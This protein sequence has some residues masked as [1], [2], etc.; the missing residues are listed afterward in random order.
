MIDYEH[1][2]SGTL[3]NCTIYTENRYVS[4][5]CGFVS[6][7]NCGPLPGAS[8]SICDLLST[9]RRMLGCLTA[10]FQRKKS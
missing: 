4:N 7:P 10:L 9:D 1:S 3:I 2:S 8:E 5:L 6:I